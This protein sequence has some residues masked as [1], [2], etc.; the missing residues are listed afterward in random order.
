MITNFLFLLNALCVLL[1]GL[2]LSF[3][4]AGL[5]PKSA[6][7][8]YFFSALTLLLV[9][10]AAYMAFSNLAV[11][12]LYPL[13]VHLPIVCLLHFF[14]RRNWLASV[15]CVVLAYLLCT[16]RLW[17]GN[18]VS[19]LFG[20]EQAASYLVQCLVTPLL[21]WLA[22]RF[23]APHVVALTQ[24]G[25]KVL[26]LF[27]AL[28]LLYYVLMLYLTVYSS[29][30][31]GAG[32]MMLDFMDAALVLMYVV[33]FV[34]VFKATQERQALEAYYHVSE[35]MNKQA[36]AEL[37]N[38][39]TVQEKDAVY[40]H[41]LRHHLAY[42]RTAISSQNTADALEYIAQITQQLDEAV[43]KRYC[44]NENVNLILSSY[45]A[46]AEQA[47]IATE[48]VVESVDFSGFSS[49]DLCSLLA[50][51]LENAICASAALPDPTDRFL[52]L[53]IFRKKHHLCIDLQNSY[54]TSPVLQGGIPT[55]SKQMHGFGVKSMVDIIEK[56]GG[57]YYFETCDTAF[58]F[59]ALLPQS[60]Q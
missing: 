38:L 44:A 8:L 27:A 52:H 10:A 57:T 11:E 51:A 25:A 54:A 17:V 48:V 47:Q 22:L 21:L 40:R 23:L 14:G 31:Y 12:K 19:S 32:P 55:T 4:F 3:A 45:L 7:R 58:V 20:Y 50:N 49:I 15:V 16:P 2:A 60:M 34:F 26:W 28:P 33:F 56:Y 5:T 46:Q 42:L 1:Y 39:R 24:Q 59:Q 30:Y 53:R 37:R 13:V 18:A 43:V 35:Q 6:P 41:D 29:W 9:Q 36:Q